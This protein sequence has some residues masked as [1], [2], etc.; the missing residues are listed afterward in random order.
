MTVCKTV[1]GRS[2]SS[3]TTVTIVNCNQGSTKE[4]CGWLQVKFG[5][6]LVHSKFLLVESKIE[7]A[8]N[9]ATLSFTRCVLYYLLGRVLPRYRKFGFGDVSRRRDAPF[10]VWLIGEFLACVT[11]AFF[12]L[13]PV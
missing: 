10:P 13:N 9:P 12:N 1:L 2:L 11:K 4:E 3:F 6:L 5:F 7:L 8:Y